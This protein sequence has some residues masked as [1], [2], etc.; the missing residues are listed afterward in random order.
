MTES[1]KAFEENY[2]DFYDLPDTELLKN[3]KGDYANNRHYVEFKKWQAAEAYGRKQAL[4]DAVACCIRK[5]YKSEGC[6]LPTP[7][8]ADE[9]RIRI[10][11]LIK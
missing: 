7:M 11:E 6:L 8:M 10:K 4:E 2:K 3:S 5:P 1:Q 9:A